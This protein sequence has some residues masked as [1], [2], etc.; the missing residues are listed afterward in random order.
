MV[1]RR[2]FLKAML[3]TAVAASLPLSLSL[4][5]A[6]VV[7]EQAL[8][9]MMSGDWVGMALIKEKG[10]TTLYINGI[11]TPL[12]SPDLYAA[13]IK[14]FHQVRDILPKNVVSKLKDW[15]VSWYRKASVEVIT[16]TGEADAN[17]GI[18]HLRVYNKALSTEEMGKLLA[19]EE[20]TT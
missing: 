1:S 20:I 18:G 14:E 19:L 12:D 13:V 3:G 10:K 4:A 5:N 7:S 15:T 6:P 9:L 17:L 2:N 16:V 11:A 8:Q